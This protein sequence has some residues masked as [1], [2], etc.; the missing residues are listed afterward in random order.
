MSSSR[1]PAR[2]LLISLGA[3]AAL[4][5]LAPVTRAQTTTTTSRNKE[6]E[7][8]EEFSRVRGLFDVD[9]PK[10]IEKFKAKVI[11]HPHFGDLLHRTYLR[12]PVGVRLGIN[13]RTEVNAEVESYLSHGLKKPAAGYGLDMI[14]LGA[15]YQWADWLKGVV[16]ASSGIN[17]GVPVGRPPT[18]LT[19]GFYHFSPYVTFSKRWPTNPRL[20]PF[21][22]FGTDVMRKST[23]PGTFAKNQ[24]H[25]DSMGTSVGFFYD[26]D[27]LKYTLVCSYWTTAVIGKG[28]KSFVSVNPSVLWELPPWLKFHSRSQWIFGIGLK[29]NFG[30]DGTEFGSSAKL[31]GEFKL[32]RLWRGAQ[33]AFSPR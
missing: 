21:A 20:T 3:F 24:P 33:S 31:R 32:S 17:I 4:G 2:K 8:P 11:V 27:E 18:D 16:D 23:V 10:T 22:T 30:P 15:K 12:V 1:S 7:N 6:G 25:S 13:D 19:D 28:S 9:L 29:A 14:R 5:L 26:R